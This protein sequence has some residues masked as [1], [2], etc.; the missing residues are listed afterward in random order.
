MI[1]T[2]TITPERKETY[3]FTEPYFVDEVRFL[4]RTEDGITDFA[5][6]EGKT[7]GV[8]RSATTKDFVSSGS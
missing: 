8:P 5:G 3:N 6:L 4:V 2:F 1:A 7:I